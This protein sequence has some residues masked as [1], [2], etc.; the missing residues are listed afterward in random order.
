[1]KW[2]HGGSPPFL[3]AAAK[4][5]SIDGFGHSE[6]AQLTAENLAS[7]NQ[8][9]DNLEEALCLVAEAVADLYEVQG[10]QNRDIALRAATPDEGTELLQAK[11][12]PVSEVCERIDLWREAIGEEVASVTNK[13]KAGTFGTEVEVKAIEAEGVYQ[14]VRV[15]GK[16]V[17]AIKPPRRYKARLVACGNFLHREKTRKSATL[18]RTELG[19]LQFADSVGHRY[20]KGLANG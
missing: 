7:M 10:P 13:H 8:V 12:I 2:V 20:P 17:A 6:L 16:L 19:H 5:S 3:R 15:P 11:V 4:A 18:D 1:M 9:V 14:V